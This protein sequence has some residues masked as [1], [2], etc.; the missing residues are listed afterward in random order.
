MNYRTIKK[1]KVD[2][3]YTSIA[4]EGNLQKQFRFQTSNLKSILAG[5]NSNNS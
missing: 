4:N 1:D 3:I 2:D 5:T